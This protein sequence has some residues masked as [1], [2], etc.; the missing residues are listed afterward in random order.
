MVLYKVS[1]IFEEDTGY[2]DYDEM[3]KLYLEHKP[4]VTII[5]GIRVG[6][7]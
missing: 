6:F 1:Y 4:K 2:I 5:P 3:G 7:L